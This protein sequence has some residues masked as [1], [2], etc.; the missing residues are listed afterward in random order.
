L[1]N[2]T[3]TLVVTNDFGCSGSDSVIITIDYS[4]HIYFPNAFSPNRDGQNDLFTYYA[5]NIKSVNLKIFNRWGEL[6]FR[7]EK[8]NAGWDGNFNNRPEPVGVYVY[9][10]M[11]TGFDGKEKLLKG[12]LT[13]IR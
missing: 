8:L 5:F 2:T 10:A 3:Y 1:Q 9:E 4:S 7:T 6:G 11:V 13:L 12:S